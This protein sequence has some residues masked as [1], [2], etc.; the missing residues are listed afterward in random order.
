MAEK[1]EIG[2]DLRLRFNELGADLT[3]TERGDL[4]TVENYDDLAQAI[5]VRL[6][7]DEGEL[8]DIGHVDF[9]S[10]L[11]EVVGELNNEATRK[12]VQSIIRECLFQEPR[13]QEVVSVNVLTDQKDPHRLDIEITVLPINSK[14]YLSLTYPFRLEG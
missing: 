6:S 13:I 5:I 9:G 7:T 1:R 8:Y 4:D 3:I 2:K 14:A 12:R 10:H 11:Y